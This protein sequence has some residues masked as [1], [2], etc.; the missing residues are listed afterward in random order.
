M[1]ATRTLFVTRLYEASL[2]ADLGFAAFNADL[3][4]ACAMLAAAT[5]SETSP[6]SSRTTTTSLTPAAFKAATSAGPIVV[7]FLSTNAP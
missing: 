3:A 7:P 4:D 6:S 5:S 2:A 1:A